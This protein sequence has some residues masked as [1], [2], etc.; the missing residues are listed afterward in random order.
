MPSM[1]CPLKIALLHR[2]SGLSSN[3]WFIEPT[4]AHNLKG[5]S[6]GSAIFAQLMAECRL[7]CGLGWA[8]RIVLD[9]GPLVLRDVAMATS[10]G[11]QFSIT[12]F[13]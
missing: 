5:I 10:F 4:R 1:S 13:V 6:I 9:G 2:G 12:G 8:Q 11:T 3:T 7:G